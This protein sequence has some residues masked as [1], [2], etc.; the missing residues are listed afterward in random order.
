MKIFPGY[1]K[2]EKKLFSETFIIFITISVISILILGAFFYF[3]TTRSMVS[4]FKVKTEKTAS[5]ISEILSVSLYNVDNEGVVKHARVY[6]L[7]GSLSGIEIISAAD[8]LLIREIIDSDSLIDPITV[9]L[10]RHNIY[11]GTATFWFNDSEIKN[12]QHTM[13]L[14]I[15]LSVI[16]SIIVSGSLIYLIIYRLFEPTLANIQKK[17]EEVADGTSH[18]LLADS[19]YR[20]F[21]QIIRSVNNMSSE[22]SSKTFKLIQS[23]K[24][25]SEIFNNIYVAVIIHD[26]LDNIIDV[27]D[28]M[29]RMFGLSSKEEALRYSLKHD[30]SD[31]ANPIEKMDKAWKQVVN[32]EERHFE[33]IARKPLTG[34]VFS[35]YISLKKFILNETPYVLTNI[36]DITERKIAEE[37]LIHA[38]KMEAL[39]TLSGGLAHDFNN[40]LVGI[41]APISM[42]EQHYTNIEIPDKDFFN[43]YIS[44]IKKSA[45]RATAI[46]SQLLSIARKQ[47]F[48]F[49]IFDLNKTLLDLIRLSEST[50]DKSIEISFNKTDK[51]AF[52]KGDLNQV[53]QVFLNLIVNAS[54]AMTFM[55]NDEEKWGGKLELTI[56][57][58]IPDEMF[59]TANTN[60]KDMDYWKIEI[61]DSGIGISKENL[62][63][64]FNPFFTTKE[65]GKGTGLGLSMVYNIIKQHEGHITVYSEQGKGTEFNVYLPV[66][67]EKTID[68]NESSDKSNRLKT[69]KEG[70]ILII[71]DDESVSKTVKTM[72]ERCGYNTFTS[73]DCLSGIDYF[74]NNFREISAVIL[75]FSMPGFTGK[76]VFSELVKIDPAVKVLLTSGFGLDD[77]T[78][79]LLEMGVKGF[80]K[81][82]FTLDQLLES[83]DSIMN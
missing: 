78:M 30:Y 53:E 16:I 57:R 58:F 15:I 29:M 73:A 43:E 44:L 19:K 33:W 77:R 13:I 59:L 9:Q 34:E 70:L 65:T 27:N 60:M 51:E 23:E 14:F 64:I 56:S 18:T 2:K 52:V 41:T 31:S 26:H 54:H 21:N 42:I 83:L 69:K 45:D 6:L 82:P 76:E 35:V 80:L 1:I 75:D 74:K 39:G 46:I 8:G 7:S 24:K 37:K 32:G 47:N 61:K 17:I 5:E 4:N 67:E 66:S 40:T 50:I 22:I 48:K 12:T 62:L 3:Y 68:K 79:P 63:K 72:L 28:T 55:R 25:Y 49:E 11:L 36:I 38:Q 71:D 20:E 10:T 81:K